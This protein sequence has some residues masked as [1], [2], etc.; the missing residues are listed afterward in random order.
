MNKNQYAPEYRNR[1]LPDGVRW[2]HD[3]GRLLPMLWLDGK[4]YALWQM[5]L[6]GLAW[7]VLLSPFFGVVMFTWLL[8]ALTGYCGKHGPYWDDVRRQNCYVLKG[9]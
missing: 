4:I 8:H 3:R 5:P 1:W 7:V 9:G 2:W 6:A